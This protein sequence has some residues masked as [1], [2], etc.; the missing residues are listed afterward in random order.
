MSGDI[1]MKN[2][3]PVMGNN[4]EAVKHTEGQR[5]HRKEIHRGDCLAMVAEEGRRWLGDAS[6][7]NAGLDAGHGR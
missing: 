1:A 7:W 5:R 4:E 6:R 3:P 2:P